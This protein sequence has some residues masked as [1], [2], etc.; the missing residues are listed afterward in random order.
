MK[1]RKRPIKTEEEAIQDFISEW[2]YK[3]SL[4]TLITDKNTTLDDIMP[5]CP[6]ETLETCP[7]YQ[8]I[9]LLESV[10]SKEE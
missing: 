9:K 6:K 8:K 7:L 10:Q 5:V 1:F 4:P 3:C 2:C